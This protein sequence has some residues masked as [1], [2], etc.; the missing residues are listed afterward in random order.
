MTT[1]SKVEFNQ[2]Q[3]EALLRRFPKSRNLPTHLTHDHHMDNATLQE[4]HAQ[5]DAHLH[6]YANKD[7]AIRLRIAELVTLNTRASK[8]SR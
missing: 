8:K 4:W 7:R 2:A 5:L 6:A 1:H 3:R